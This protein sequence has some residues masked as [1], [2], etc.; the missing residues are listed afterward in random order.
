VRRAVFTSLIALAACGPTVELAS[1]EGDHSSGTSA[2]TAMPTST[3]SSESTG[4]PDATTSS[5]T[6]GTA[7]ESGGAD[8]TGSDFLVV[9]DAGTEPIDCDIWAQ[10]C[11]RG[12]KCMPWS[13]DDGYAWNATRCAPI[14]DD[15]KAPG[16]TCTV[17]D[18]SVSG[19][20]DCEKG[21][22][23]W[24]VDPKTNVGECVGMCQGTAMNPLCT[25]PC[26]ACR[27]MNEGVL[28][29]C[30]ASC[31]PLVNE[32]AW[33]QVCYPLGAGFACFPD[34]QADIDLGDPCNFAQDCDPGNFCAPVDDVPNCAGDVGCCARFCDVEAPDECDSILPGTAC[35]P[36]FDSGRGPAE[37]CGATTVIGACVIA[38]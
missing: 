38:R 37:S 2:S 30:L 14:D 10:N 8:P 34:V 12:S 17:V 28:T 11:P 1:D 18:S 26:D 16:E 36:W 29:L 21:A 22:M 7:T 24:D 13:N 35:V 6:D 20:D 32:C 23:C 31:D 15:P 9:P 4:S 5:S 3:T 33:D 27:I 25:N 19:I